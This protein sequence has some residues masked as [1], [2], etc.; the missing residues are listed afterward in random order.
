MRTANRFHP[1]RVARARGRGAAT[2]SITT[3][4]LGVLVALVFAAYVAVTL[5]AM[6]QRL[7]QTSFGL[8]ETNR[9]LYGMN[10]RL[11]VTNGMLRTTNVRLEGMDARL[12]RA[13]AELS[14][15]PGDLHNM[16]SALTQTDRQLRTT[17][18][19]LLSM[20]GQIRAMAQKITHAKLLF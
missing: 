1:I 10:A 3:V 7:Y 12:A 17:I 15:M 6:S 8:A 14:D 5:H 16:A 2:A 9:L 13:N 18:Q 4:V 20:A 11:G 19:T